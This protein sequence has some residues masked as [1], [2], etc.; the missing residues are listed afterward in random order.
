MQ[1]MEA[2]EISQQ[3]P[4]GSEMGSQVPTAIH[5]ALSENAEVRVLRVARRAFRQSAQLAVIFGQ[6]EVD[7]SSSH[8]RGRHADVKWT[9]RNS[10]DLASLVLDLT[11]SFSRAPCGWFSQKGALEGADSHWVPCIQRQLFD[12]P[13]TITA[14]AEVPQQ[15]LIARSRSAGNA[16]PRRQD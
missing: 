4:K 2:S 12:S 15:Q 13:E 7:K 11:G 6:R 5:R 9:P 3:S 8:D 1:F 14:C 10:S 16:H